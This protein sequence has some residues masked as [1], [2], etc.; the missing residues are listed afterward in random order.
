MGYDSQ[1]KKDFEENLDYLIGAKPQTKPIFYHKMAALVGSLFFLAD[2][3]ERNGFPELFNQL[4]EKARLCKKNI[5]E[6]FQAN[7]VYNGKSVKKM[8]IAFLCDVAAGYNAASD[9]YKS[10]YIGAKIPDKMAPGTCPSSPKVNNAINNLIG[11]LAE[12]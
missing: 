2:L 8:N 4:V 10:K 9:K 5:Q 11:K 3:A 1:I 12:D 7:W 6:Q